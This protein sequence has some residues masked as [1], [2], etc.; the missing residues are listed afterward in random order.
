MSHEPSFSEHKKNIEE[1][2]A[3]ISIAME[4]YEEIDKKFDYPCK[5]VNNS[6]YVMDFVDYKS[7]NEFKPIPTL[8]MELG[9]NHIAILYRG[10]KIAIGYSTIIY[11]IPFDDNYEERIGNI[12]KSIPFITH[13]PSTCGNDDESDE[14]KKH[15]E[16]KTVDW[17]IC[18]LGTVVIVPVVVF[19]IIITIMIIVKEYI[20]GPN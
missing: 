17:R 20:Y 2:Y 18:N 15:K 7:L 11:E 9:N 5:L 19:S 4:L 13:I 12:I 10:D 16:T 8:V 3:T 6:I 14:F 1:E